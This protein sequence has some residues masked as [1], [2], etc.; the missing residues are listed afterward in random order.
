MSVPTRLD[1]ISARRLV[2]AKPSYR[3]GQRSLAVGERLELRVECG[4]GAYVGDTIVEKRIERTDGEVTTVTGF[5]LRPPT[6]LV[7]EDRRH[8][9]RV[10]IASERPPLA[11]IL[12]APSHRS[13]ATATVV[14]LALGGVRL[15]G[16]RS[17]IRSGDRVVV[18]G[19][20]DT[21]RCLHAAG[22]VVHAAEIPGAP[23][24]A[25]TDIGIRFTDTV[26][27]VAAY[28]RDISARGTARRVA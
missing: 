25:C 6:S 27:E 13:L 18:R 7:L 17:L 9:D 11:E 3:P 23:L 28:I 16:P 19:R 22:V 8:A 24:D 15:R 12:H 21:E 14:D 20:L 2:V 10:S 5:V 4:G 26:P 1:E